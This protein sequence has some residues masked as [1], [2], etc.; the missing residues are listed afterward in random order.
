MFW[1]NGRWNSK[2]MKWQS[3]NEV[4]YSIDNIYK[5][6][7]VIKNALKT[8]NKKSFLKKYDESF[9]FQA[10][11]LLISFESQSDFSSPTLDPTSPSEP[12]SSSSTLTTTTIFS[13]EDLFDFFPATDT[14][15]LTNSHQILQD[16][17]VRPTPFFNRLITKLLRNSSDF[18]KIFLS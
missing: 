14:D 18:L 9:F 4:S 6:L 12:F 16:Y 3:N 17:F 1:W 8:F 2:L 15:F 5:Y 10:S 7:L 11:D 13:T